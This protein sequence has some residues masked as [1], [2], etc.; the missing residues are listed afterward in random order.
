M[1][2]TIEDIGAAWVFTRSSGAW[3]QQGSEPTAAG[4]NGNG[5][6]GLS[7]ALS[8]EGNTAV[9]GIL[10]A[11]TSGDVAIWL[12]S[13]GAFSSGIDP[14]ALPLNWQVAGTGDFNGDGTGDI[15]WRNTANG[16]LAIWFMS[17]GQ[18]SSAVDVGRLSTDW[19]VVGTGD[20]EGDG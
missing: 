10:W 5:D 15:L 16:E 7:A 14:G 3:S 8:A 19:T 9:I 11:D 13:K 2:G 20:F 17:G 1:G 4:E 12:M 18:V 6:F